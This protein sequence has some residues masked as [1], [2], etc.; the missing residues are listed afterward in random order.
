MNLPPESEKM[1]REQS[2]CS[3]QF[4]CSMSVY[5]IVSVPITDQRK[6]QTQAI[7]FGR[8]SINENSMNMII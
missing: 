2:N 3:V 4:D 5:G 8:K 6:F 7:A 1:I